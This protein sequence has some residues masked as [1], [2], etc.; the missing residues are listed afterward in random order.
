MVRFTAM[1]WGDADDPFTS[2]VVTMDDRPA[3]PFLDMEMHWADNDDLHFQVHLKT[4]QR[5]QY[6]NKGSNHRYS[7]FEAIPRGVFIRLSRLTTIT[8]ANRDMPINERY[9]LHAAALIQAGLVN[10]RA[11]FP[12][13]QEARMMDSEYRRDVAVVEDLEVPDDDSVV[14]KPD[15][16]S[17]QP[18]R[19]TFVKFGFI[20]SILVGRSI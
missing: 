12:T 5:L 20:Q 14:S 3:F 6:L 8:D 13:L 19:D 4:G 2:D 7:T 10:P 9:P 15:R 17:F 16:Q 18:G 1:V 11:G